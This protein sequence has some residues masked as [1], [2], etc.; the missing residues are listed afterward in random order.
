MHLIS[1]KGTWLVPIA[2]VIGAPLVPATASAVVRPNRHATAHEASTAAPHL[3]CCGSPGPNP[4][5]PREHHPTGAGGVGGSIPAPATGRRAP[6]RVPGSRVNLRAAAA[7]A[8][9]N[10]YTAPEYF[11]DDCADFVSQALLVGGGDPEM[12][13]LPPTNDRYWY[14]AYAP[15]GG[16]WYTHSWSVAHDLAVHLELVHSYWIRYWRD[17]SPGDVIFADW[18]GSSFAGISHV[19]IITGMR[20]GQPLITQH[21]PSQRNVSLHYWLTRGGRDVHVWIAVPNEG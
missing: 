12:G 15:R 3:R 9:A 13:G 18:S 21:T 11:G 20:D 14:L 7:W 10:T 17:T 4:P 16:F 5:S 19:G 1:M 8:L 6:E 2:L